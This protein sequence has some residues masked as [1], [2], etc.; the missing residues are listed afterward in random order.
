MRR[1]LLICH[2]LLPS[3]LFGAVLSYSPSSQSFSYS[4]EG[5]SF[6]SLSSSIRI[7]EGPFTAGRLSDKAIQELFSPYGRK[8]ALDGISLSDDEGGYYVLASPSFGGGLWRSW[9]QG[10]LSAGY[11][12]ASEVSDTIFRHVDERGGYESIHLR[13]DLSLSFIDVFIKGSISAES[14]FDLMYGGT[15]HLA[16]LSLTYAEGEVL[17]LTGGEGIR[18]Q[19]KMEIAGKAIRY[20]ASLLFGS[21]PIAAGSFRRHEG[22]EEL[23]VTVGSVTL[24]AHRRGS[25]SS[26]GLSSSS[27]EYLALFHGLSFGFDEELLPVFGYEDDTLYLRYEEGLIKVRCSFRTERLKLT[28]G[29]ATDGT[30]TSSIRLE[31]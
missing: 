25:F 13:G 27:S 10:S 19:L 30:V 22:S 31:L 12:A 7:S 29:Y 1:L 15:V 14:G 4:H 26:G 2:L 8:E 20:K 21:D 24:E 18:R 6:Y 16:D 28:L 23:Y 11:V 17:M 3:L 5:L 9:K